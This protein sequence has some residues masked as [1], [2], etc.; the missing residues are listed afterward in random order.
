VL[1]KHYLQD[2]PVIVH[3]GNGLNGDRHCPDC[4]E[5]LA[6]QEGCHSCQSCGFTHCG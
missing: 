1:E 6:F 3:G 2:R 5:T 4:G